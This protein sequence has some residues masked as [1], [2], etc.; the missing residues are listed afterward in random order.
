MPVLGAG[1]TL[2]S[3]GFLP[4]ARRHAASLVEVI[5]KMDPDGQMPIVGL[6]PSEVYTLSDEFLD[7]LP[8]DSRAISVASRAWMIDEFLLRPGLSGNPRLSWYK[9]CNELSRETVY[10]HG[11]CYQK[12]RPPNSDGYPTGV[13]ASM[14]LLKTAGYHV[15]QID[16]G[17]CGMAGA[18]GYEVE[19]YQLSMQVGELSL[20]PALR[21]A[22]NQLETGGLLIAASGVSCHA[23]IEDG[24]QKSSMHP[25]QL[26]LRKVEQVNGGTA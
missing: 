22:S 5:Y 6:E 25:I 13:A 23:Q 14:A 1:R 18:F 19:H 3:K 2:L 10:L 7:L 12:A 26:F 21:E 4:A 20:F 16:S 24:V 15:H 17:C 8:H 9:S 11:H